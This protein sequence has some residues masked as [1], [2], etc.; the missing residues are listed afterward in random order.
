MVA[1]EINKLNPNTLNDV[2]DIGVPLGEDMITMFYQPSV[3]DIRA[4]LPS[5]TLGALEEN[6]V[7]A[8]KCQF[9]G[10]N[11]AG[12]TSTDNNGREMT[13]IGRLFI[14]T[15]LRRCFLYNHSFARVAFG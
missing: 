2:P 6:D 11:H 7:P 10:N 1:I 4:G 14:L 15:G 13:H 12:E 5:Q 3:F 8:T 9:T